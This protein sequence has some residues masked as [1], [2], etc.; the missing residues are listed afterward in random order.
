MDEIEET[1]KR[2]LNKVARDLNLEPSKSLKLETNSQHGYFFRVTLKV[3]N[4]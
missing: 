3:S 4:L 2:E 1:L